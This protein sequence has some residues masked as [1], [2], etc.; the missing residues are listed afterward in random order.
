M[1]D[2]DDDLK[3]LALEFLGAYVTM[4]TRADA[5]ASYLI[6]NAQAIE[7]SHY[8]AG[9][10][11]LTDDERWQLVDRLATELDRPGPDLRRLK[12][13]KDHRNCIAHMRL[14]IGDQEGRPVL[15]GSK[16]TRTGLEQW[17]ATQEQLRSWIAE[18]T[19]TTEEIYAI[20]DGRLYQAVTVSRSTSWNVLPADDDDE[21]NQ[22]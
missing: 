8:L 21:E 9:R 12:A 4:Q 14:Q 1:T 10:L 18:A 15:F 3:A 7:S 13:L 19:R 16:Q 17:S 6:E 22:E 20:G 5:L 2:A 11:R